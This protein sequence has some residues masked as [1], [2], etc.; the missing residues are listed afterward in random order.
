M[1]VIVALG[2][3]ATGG[4][5]TDA[6]VPAPDAGPRDAGTPDSGAPDAGPPDAGPPDTGPD[7]GPPDAGPADGCLGFTDDFDG[8]SAMMWTPVNLPAGGMWGQFG[9]HWGLGT[10]DHGPAADHTGDGELWA[11]S[12]DRGYRAFEHSALESPVI[13]LS[14]ATSA[15]F[16]FWHWLETEWCPLSCGELNPVPVALDGAQVQCWDGD[17]WDLLEPTDGYPSFVRIWDSAVIPDHPMKD[18][19]GFAYDPSVGSSWV[20]VEM[21]LP[22]Q[23]RRFDA[24]VRF[25]FGSDSG[26]A[27]DGA[28]W[29]VDDV[30]MDVTCP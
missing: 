4:G 29:F 11:V 15:T 7:T 6:T 23:C 20:E 3:C 8:A 2:G 27:R 12:V 17:S 18:E 10:P 22:N 24:Q 5:A 19:R 30:S 25:R 14:R 21:E 16:R 26:S 1:T 28:G 9:H 13:D